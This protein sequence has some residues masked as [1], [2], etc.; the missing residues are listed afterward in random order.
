MCGGP[1]TAIDPGPVRRP[2]NWLQWVNESLGAAELQEVR[3]SVNRGMPYGSP[4]WAS[5]TAIVLGL[6]ASLRPRGRP[7]NEIEM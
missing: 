6:R 7:R 2:E 1:V 4:T 5:R 3:Q